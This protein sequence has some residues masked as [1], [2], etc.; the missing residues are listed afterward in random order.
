MDLSIKEAAALLGRSPRALRQWI[1]SKRLAATRTARGYRVRSEDLPL[2]EAQRLSLK[3]RAEVT[4]KIV[5]DLLP[6]RAATTLDRRR[7]SLLDLDA[8]RLARDATAQIHKLAAELS[9]S[10]ALASAARLARRGT[11]NLAEGAHEFDI[12]R[13]HACLSLARKRFARGTATQLQ[14]S[15]AGSGGRTQSLAAAPAARRSS[16]RSEFAL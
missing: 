11:R 3:E 15:T 5:D 6:S 9:A 12:G 10:H 4:R 14:R 13:K 7:R 1:E 16:S 8:F 2:T